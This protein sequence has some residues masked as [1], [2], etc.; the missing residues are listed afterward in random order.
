M[1]YHLG[2]KR[3]SDLEDA[4]QQYFQFTDE[5]DD[6]NPTLDVY[7]ILKYLKQLDPTS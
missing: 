3:S 4:L 6:E 2:I 5:L 1:L 7:K